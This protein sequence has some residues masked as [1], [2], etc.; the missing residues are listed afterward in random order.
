MMRNVFLIILTVLFIGG[1]TMAPRYT[2]P[3]AP[4]PK[5]WPE[6]DAYK[7]IKTSDAPSAAE[8][9]W[10]DFISDKKLEKVIEMALE[11]NRDFKL[12]ALNVE[13][14]R[15]YYGIQRAELLPALD[16]V[17]TGS[18]QRV[19]ADLSN[20]KITGVTEQYSVNL[21]VLSWEID[22]FGRLQS[23]KD[24][25]LEE[26]LATE[27]AHRSARI[28]LI[29][30]TAGAYWTY[31]ADRENLKLAEDTLK[32]QMNSY[33]LIKR[34][35]DVGLASELDLRRSQTQ[36]DSAKEIVYRYTQLV[37]QD[38]NALNL[39]AG[40]VV[41]KELLPDGFDS[42]IP[43]KDI[44]PGLSSEVL[45]RRPDIMASEH[46]LKSIN[47]MIGAARAAFF[48]RISLTT[49]MGTASAELSRLF[50]SGQDTWN[51]SPQV[52]MP[53][54][55]ARIWAAYDA[56]KVEREIAL[57]GYEKTIQTAFREVADA[58]AVRGTVEQQLAAQQSFVDAVAETYRLSSARY[59]KGIDSYL[60][61]LDAQRS[62]FSAQQGLIALRLAK[63]TNLVTLY[64]VLGWGNE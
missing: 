36:V 30:T 8:L 32:T 33:D 54:F 41:P 24:K 57:A 55:D 56:A 21:G 20:K 34:R 40:K 15:A 45:L 44:S 12:A 38:E 18:R 14:A 3:P 26:Y 58:L 35:Y 62:L 39:L 19:P 50:R 23:L 13:K 60:S 48:P 59:M 16:A 64:K 11:N 31:A 63:T 43:P 47:A 37:A 49:T 46:M 4:I 6:G 51:F 28:M 17:G 52:V 29:A 61:V 7:D 5:A 22:F 27:E 2:R 53:I 25:A 9:K 10:R 42:V 1:C